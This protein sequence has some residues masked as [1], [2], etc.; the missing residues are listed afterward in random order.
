MKESDA[1]IEEKSR[2]NVN[3][4]EETREKR[5]SETSSEKLV[6][7]PVEQVFTVPRY[8]EVPQIV[9]RVRQESVERPKRRL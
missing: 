4:S 3:K 1:S 9:Q 2:D 5:P 6:E 8:G 7:W